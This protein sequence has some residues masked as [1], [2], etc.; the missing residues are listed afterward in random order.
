M[1][2]L[3]VLV[4][5]WETLGVAGKIIG[6]AV[7]AHPVASAITALTPTPHDDK[8]LG[9][10]YKYILEPLALVVYRAKDRS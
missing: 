10:L 3:M 4:G 6:V 5:A 2:D 8:I 9:K 1:T 7:V